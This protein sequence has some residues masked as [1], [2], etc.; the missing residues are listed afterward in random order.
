LI[1]KRNQCEREIARLSSDLSVEAERVGEAITRYQASVDDFDRDVA[2]VMGTNETDLRCL[3]ILIQ[4]K[5][6]DTTPRQVADRLGLTTGSVTT[7]LYRLETLGYIDR[8][9]HPTDRRKLIVRATALAYQRA[10]ELYG[11][12]VADGQRLLARYSAE[13]LELVA[14]FLTEADALQQEHLRRLRQVPP[15]RS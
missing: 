2:R 9:P 8:S 4:S 5:S 15:H 7:L 10:G 1:V 6:Q 11:P 14:D 12:L 3:E 13:Q